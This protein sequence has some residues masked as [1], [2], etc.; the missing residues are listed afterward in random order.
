MSGRA[1]FPMRNPQKKGVCKAALFLSSS[2]VLNTEA[3]PI[4]SGSW[5]I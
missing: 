2:Q 4:L 1:A 3:I 5:T